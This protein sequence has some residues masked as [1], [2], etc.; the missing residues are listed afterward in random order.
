[1]EKRIWA[2]AAE[3]DVTNTLHRY[4]TA[5]SFKDDYIV[6]AISAR[7]VNDKGAVEK[8]RRFLEIARK[9]EPVNM[10]DA[11]NGALHRPAKSLNP[12]VHWRRSSAPDFDAV[13]NGVSCPTTVAAVFDNPDV[14]V[15]FINELK[16]ADL[17]LSINISG[18]LD[19]AQACIR[20]AGLE[21]HSVEYS[22]GFFGQTDL[23]TDRR[24]LEL[25]T[26]CGHG[27]LSFSFV[28]KLRD[29]VKQGRRTPEQASVT[30]AR[31]CSCGVFNTTRAC[32]IF[33][34]EFSDKQR[35]ENRGQ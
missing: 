13:I 8:Q 24:T 9:Y 12:L 19:H 4:G 5:E 28:R 21:R 17:G 26:M 22:L 31:F 23:L 29:W 32:R 35:R 30:L 2:S 6:F 10:G 33:R 14:V 25:S 16:K 27:M 18:S 11:S 20:R 15:E 3:H 34:E 7:G 1:V